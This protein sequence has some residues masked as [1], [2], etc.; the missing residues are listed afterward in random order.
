MVV[1]RHGCVSFDPVEPT[2]PTRLGGP[3]DQKN[4][5][6]PAFAV[7][8]RSRVCRQRHPMGLPSNRRGRRSSTD[9]DPKGLPI[10]VRN[11]A[12]AAPP[13]TVARTARQR[14]GPF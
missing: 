9:P 12:R 14:G 10:E 13:G 5:A 6:M 4:R 3:S 2:M 11:N 1:T 8:S 7:T